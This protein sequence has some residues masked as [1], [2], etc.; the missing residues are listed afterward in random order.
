MKG[1]NKIGGEDSGTDPM[2]V[3]LKSKQQK[4][5]KKAAKDEGSDTDPMEV[6]PPPT[7]KTTQ[8]K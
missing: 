2:E 6:I 4:P 7:K 8:G 5:A 1:P 3:P